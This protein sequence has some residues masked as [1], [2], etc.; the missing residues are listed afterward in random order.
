MKH[1]KFLIYVFILLGVLILLVQ[2]HE[3]FNTKVI[4]RAN[5]LIAKYESSE[6]SIYII[7]A[8]AFTLGLIIA[9][10]YNLFDR[11]QLKREI[12]SLRKE[13]KEKDKELNSLRN[14]PILSEKVAPGFHG[15]DMELT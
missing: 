9:W 10:V 11:M 8:T 15:N 2:N 4:F 5:L 7:S 1:I 13:S 14:M 6:M 3:S 12:S